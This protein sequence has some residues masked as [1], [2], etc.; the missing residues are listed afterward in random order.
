MRVLLVDDEQYILE[1][2]KHLIDWEKYGFNEVLIENTSTGA[3]SCLRKKE[4]DLLIS[5][6]RMPE[7]SGIDLLKM[8]NLESS[9]TKVIFLTGY[10][11]FEYARVGI[12]CGLFDY[13]LKPVTKEKFVDVITRFTNCTDNKKVIQMSSY[14][15]MMSSLALELKKNEYEEKSGIVND[16]KIFFKVKM[17]EM[18][19]I[20]EYWGARDSL[21]VNKIDGYLYSEV[22][23]T[24][25]EMHKVFYHFFCNVDFN[26]DRFIKVK[27]KILEGLINFDLKN[28]KQMY[29]TVDLYED[30]IYFVVFLLFKINQKKIPINQEIITKLKNVDNC[31][32]QLQQEVSLLND[33]KTRKIII[34]KIQVYIKENLEKSLSLDELADVVYLHPVYLS[35]LYKKE[36]G[37]NLST[38]IL[39]ERLNKGA[40]LLIS[41]QLKVSD[42]GKMIGYRTSQYFIKVFKEKYQVTPQQYRREKL[43]L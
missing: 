8:V 31:F 35:K 16:S 34:K 23:Q 40:E 27:A 2:V 10:S 18:I 9:K 19:G 24:E 22:F 38:Y 29:E 26:I 4:V 28:I 17:N 36:T 30:K 12:K 42:I 20:S 37:T 1:Y 13:L 6:I 5:D 43:C 33:V 7:A 32:D 14:D 41:S 21:G 39:D 25:E 3:L 11:E 15:L